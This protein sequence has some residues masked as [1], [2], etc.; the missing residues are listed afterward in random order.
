MT[1]TERILASKA[2]YPLCS[3][4]PFQTANLICGLGFFYANLIQP[5]SQLRWEGSLWYTQR[6]GVGSPVPVVRV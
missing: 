1:T 3:F 4:L 5:L 6:G 2:S